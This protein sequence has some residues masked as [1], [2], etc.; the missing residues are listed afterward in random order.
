MLQQTTGARVTIGRTPNE[1]PQGRPTTLA[2][3]P[4]S[5][6]RCKVEIDRLLNNAVV[7]GVEPP[8]ISGETSTM[9]IAQSK[10]AILIGRN[11]DTIRLLQMK[12]GCTIRIEK[13]HEVAPGAT[14]RLV[15]LI[16]DAQVR[17]AAKQEIE[18]LMDAAN[19]SQGPIDPGMLLSGRTQKQLVLSVDNNVVGLVIGR[20]GENIKN[21]Q[22]QTGARVQVDKEPTGASR[23]VTISAPTDAQLQQAQQMIH[24]VI[25]QKQMGGGAQMHQVPMPQPQ[26]G[27][28]MQQYGGVQQQYGGYPQQAYGY[29]QQQQYGYPQQQ[30]PVQQPG[31][32]MMQMGQA[33]YPQAAAQQ[34]ADPDRAAKRKSY[35]DHY[36]SQGYAQA[37][38]E[39][40][41][42]HYLNMM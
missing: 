29:A 24:A 8:V 34:Q 3:T 10:V 5:I 25:Q 19:S 22:S 35:V 42:D 2:G 37:D 14:E 23:N 36:L 1:H 18:R 21:I 38:A 4:E 16:G 28:Q 11:G 13:D 6:E 7:G 20:G 31:M 32:Q 33:G 40:F 17:E 39:K 9:T 15:T 27:Y 41:A 12:T 30:M 26:Y